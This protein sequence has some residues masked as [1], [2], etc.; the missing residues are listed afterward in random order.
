MDENTKKAILEKV[1][2]I[3]SYMQHLIC[4]MND[5]NMAVCNSV[6]VSLTDIV[7]IANGKVDNKDD[8]NQ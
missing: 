7:N 8:K 4:E 2:N 6:N 3:H 1:N 5:N